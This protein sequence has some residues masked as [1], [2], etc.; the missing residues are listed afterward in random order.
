MTQ[1]GHDVKQQRTGERCEAGARRVD[2]C[3]AGDC[4]LLALLLEQADSASA[5]SCVHSDDRE[6]ALHKGYHR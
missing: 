3:Q 6:A 1:M 2:G 5:M 4:L